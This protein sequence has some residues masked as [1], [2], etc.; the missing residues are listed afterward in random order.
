MKV[1]IGILLAFAGEVLV[2]SGLIMPSGAAQ[3][4]TPGVEPVSVKTVALPKAYLGQ[5]FRF[6]LEAQGGIPPMEWHLA[7]GSLPKGLALGADGILSGKPTESGEFHFVVTVSDSGQPAQQRNQE[8]ALR[9]VA[10]LLVEWSRYPKVAG[11]RI[12][13]AVK[14]SNQ[15]GEDFDLTFITVAVNE[16]GRATA[17]GYQRFPLKKNTAD[18]EIPFGEN[19]PRGLYEVNVDVVAEV[20]AANT[21]HRAHLVTK[22]KLQVLGAP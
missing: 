20:A 11:Q 17:L 3:Q 18:Q 13:G 7:E 22:E 5:E 4:A 14:I 1:G 15:T 16:N 12:E 8:L 10:P 6:Q 19:L 9:V 2:F 21:I